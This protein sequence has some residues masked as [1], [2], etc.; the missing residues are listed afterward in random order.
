MR[1]LFA[2]YLQLMKKQIILFV[3]AICCMSI[4]FSQTNP[5]PTEDPV[6]PIVNTEKTVKNVFNVIAAS[7]TLNEGIIHIYQ[8]SRIEKLFLDRIE[9]GKTGVMSGYRVQVFSSNI[10]RTAKNEAFGIESSIREKF[11]E[12]SV[13]VSYTSPFWKVRVGDLRTT[14]EAQALREELAHAF[15]D[16]RKE[17]YVVKDEILVSGLK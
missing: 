4:G 2:L 1:N 15:P 12:T 7:D 3:I 13:Y 5:P 16:M 11:P 9:L 14:E 17:M 10:Q 8:D 6:P